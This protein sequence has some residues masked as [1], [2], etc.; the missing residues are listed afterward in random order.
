MTRGTRPQLEPVYEPHFVHQLTGIK[1][2]TDD[3][4]TCVCVCMCVNVCVRVCVRIYI[5]TRMHAYLNQTYR[6]L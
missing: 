4:I 2:C 3:D 6:V 1:P 5:P